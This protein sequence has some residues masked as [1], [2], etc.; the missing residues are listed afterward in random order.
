MCNATRLVCEPHTS[1]SPPKAKIARTGCSQGTWQRYKGILSATPCKVTDTQTHADHALLLDGATK[2]TAEMPSREAS[3][4]CTAHV[5]GMSVHPLRKQR[6]RSAREV[7]ALLRICT[8]CWRP[9]LSLQPRAFHRKN[10][11]SPGIAGFCLCGMGAVFERVNINTVPICVRR[12]MFVVVRV[13][14][15]PCTPRV[16]LVPC[17]PPH[18]PW[19]SC[20]VR[21]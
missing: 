20:R 18:H 16:P 10:A 6:S 17:S 5:L 11:P 14:P 12:A 3:Q 2:R 13:A 21:A 7:G 19:R 9:A 15:H 8:A 1:R 4:E